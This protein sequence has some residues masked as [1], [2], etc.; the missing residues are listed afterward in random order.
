MARSQLMSDIL[1]KLGWLPKGAGRSGGSVA[2]PD[3][4]WLW[5]ERTFNTVFIILIFGAALVY[6][7]ALFTAMNRGLWWVAVNYLA[8]IC[9]LFGLVF[10]KRVPFIFRAALGSL[11]FLG[12]GWVTLHMSGLYGSG[13]LWR[14]GQG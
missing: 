14:R 1:T 8:V 2:D 13:R 9:I 11:L 10:F 4:I 7:P 3:E 5:R 12:V 6:L